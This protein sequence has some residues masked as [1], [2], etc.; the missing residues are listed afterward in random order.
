MKMN[1]LHPAEQLA[2]IMKRVYG[3]RLTTT[4]GGN[5]SIK[6]ENGDV[7][8]TPGAIDKG[9]LTKDDMVCIKADG[10]VIGRHKPSS[11]YPFH[12]K[13]YEVRPDLHAVLHAHPSA[14][15]AFSIVR[16]LPD[17]SLT[18]QIY[19]ECGKPGMAKYAMTGSEELGE[20][21]AEVF[22]EN[23]NV[24]ILENHGV[25]VGAECVQDAFGV[26]ETMESAAR[27]EI[28]AAVLGTKVP[29][30]AELL[31]CGRDTQFPK[32][33][34]YKE[35]V[36]AYA[37]A[38]KE[39][40]KTICDFAAR[41]YRQELVN[42]VQGS[43]SQRTGEDTFVITPYHKDRLTLEPS[44]IVTVK[45][46]CV[47]EGKVPSRT[48]AVHKAIYEQHPGIQNIA[49]CQPVHV[50]AFAVTEVHL[51]SRTIPE[52]YIMMRDIPRLEKPVI[53]ME[54]SAVAAAFNESTP[55]VLAQN[56][57]VIV[58]GESMLQVFDRLE[59]TEYSAMSIIMS[60]NQGEIVP[61]DEKGLEDIRKGFNLK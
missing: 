57:G 37:S 36:C 51:D 6:D 2:I 32:L 40:K 14:L 44:D 4:S 12:L 35:S 55:I 1:M 9:N 58:T 16:K 22:A 61:I 41:A 18:P 28:K 49:I 43:F 3:Q 20:R 33:P 60:K 24:A 39:A 34:T 26:F 11:E 19:Y 5:I 38:E 27:M 56:D 25:V 47:E 45:K 46:G 50:T 21:I 59:V 17:T 23:R 10:T 31:E 54:P 13:I 7:W 52:S 15:V 8:I 53:M 30:Y 42:S 29:L 48:V